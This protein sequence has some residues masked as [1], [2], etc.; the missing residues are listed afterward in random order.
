MEGSAVSI[1]RDWNTGKIPYFTIPPAIHASSMPEKAVAVAPTAAPGDDVEMSN[2][3]GDARILNTLS[4]AFTIEG[5]LD[6]AG[7]EAAWDGEEPD[8]ADDRPAWEV[9]DEAEVDGLDK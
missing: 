2:E 9:E 7:D 1:L 8:V 4:E 3:I 5:L 6:H